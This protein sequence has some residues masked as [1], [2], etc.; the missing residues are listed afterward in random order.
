M[1]QLY[2]ILFLQTSSLSIVLKFTLKYHVIMSLGQHVWGFF[3][4]NTV[5]LKAAD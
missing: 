2:Y 5:G 1:S 3:S 4:P